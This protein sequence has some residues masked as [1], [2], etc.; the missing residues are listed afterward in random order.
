[1]SK[2]Q[3]RPVPHTKSRLL[4]FLIFTA[5]AG[6]I[7][8]GLLFPAAEPV[9]IESAMDQ[10]PGTASTG[11]EI[12]P[13][14]DKIPIYLVGA[15]KN[16]GIYLIERGSYLYQLIEQSGGLLDTAAAE[17]VNLAFRLD[18]NQL[19]KIPTDAEVAADP[20]SA[21]AITLTTAGALVDLNTA[22]E[23]Q[24]DAL[25]GVGPSTAKAI[26]EY[27]K[28]N[29]PFKCIEDLMKVPGIKESRFSSLKDMVIVRG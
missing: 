19:I 12:K 28:K 10:P 17:S 13:L 8:W 21:Q 2:N 29:G 11:S 7:V 5:V 23:T 26:V 4:I 24:L 27:R 18:E 15:V 16:P 25:P 1:M 14:S 20:A 3:T 9:I 22:D 6:S